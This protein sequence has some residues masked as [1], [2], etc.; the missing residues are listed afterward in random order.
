[1]SGQLLGLDQISP[2]I[3]GL[4]QQLVRT[5]DK[6]ISRDFCIGVREVDGGDTEARRHADV[7]GGLMD[8]VDIRE[9]NAQPNGQQC[10][11]A[12]PGLWQDHQK[13][14]ASAILWYTKK[15]K[16]HPLYS[17]FSPK[18]VYF[19]EYRQRSL[20]LIRS[21]TASFIDARR[22]AGVFFVS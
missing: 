12:Q 4:I 1:M 14:L 8:G 3:F 19:P 2:G 13:F 7:V 21:E 9:G 5:C 15:N 17:V 20:L 18:P 10:A 16:P 11:I 22:R 6:P